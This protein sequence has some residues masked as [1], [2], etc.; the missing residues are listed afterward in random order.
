MT[1]DKRDL[2]DPQ[3]LGEQLLRCRPEYSRLTLSE[4]YDQYN[5]KSNVIPNYPKHDSMGTQTAAAFRRELEERDDK[6]AKAA[7]RDLQAGKKVSGFDD[8]GA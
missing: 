2:R 3:K 6:Y 5:F 4:A 1:K 8:A 7:L